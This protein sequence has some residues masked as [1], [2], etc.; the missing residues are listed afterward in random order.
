[1]SD[2]KAVGAVVMS[3]VMIIGFYTL[4]L[5]NSNGVN[6]D[7]SNLGLAPEATQAPPVNESSPTA[8]TPNRTRTMPLARPPLDASIKSHKYNTGE[9]TV[10]SNFFT[11]SGSEEFSVSISIKNDKITKITSEM[12]PSSD[13]SLFF[14]QQRFAPGING[15]VV[16]K[17]ID[18]A[19]LQF[20]VNGATL[21]SVAFNKALERI[22][23]IA[24]RSDHNIAYNGA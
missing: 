19:T 3:A 10:E 18:E 1:M 6:T 5:N 4:V 12:N 8:Q 20:A 15:Q 7:T 24:T 14:Q 9:F 23:E 11:P 13:M 16:G 17:N 22:K 2:R 21:H